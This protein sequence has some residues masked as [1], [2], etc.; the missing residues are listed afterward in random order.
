M[1]YLFINLPL[2]LASRAVERRDVGSTGAGIHAHEGGR[3]KQV[4]PGA[5]FD[6]RRNAAHATSRID[7]RQQPVFEI[8]KAEGIGFRF[9]IWKGIKKEEISD[10][11]VG[12]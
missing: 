1:L 2:P 12:Q 11:M 9:R 4:S 7:R 6:P 3:G 8:S 10:N 5:V